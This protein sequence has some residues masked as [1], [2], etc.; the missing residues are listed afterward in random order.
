MRTFVINMKQD[1]A[2][3]KKMVSNFS[4]T[5]LNIERF[6]A[7]V[8]KDLRNREENNISNLCKLFCTNGM[9]GAMSSHMEV[10]KKIVHE[11]IPVAIIMEDDVSPVKDFND[12]LLKILNHYL[13]DNFDI[14]MLGNSSGSV[15]CD[16]NK[17]MN[18]LS[19]FFNHRKR[20]NHVQVN[21]WIHIP[22]NLSGCQ[23]YIISQKGAKKVLNQIKKISFHADDVIYS[24]DIHLYAVVPLLLR[25]DGAYEN[26]SLGEKHFIPLSFLNRWNCFGAPFAWALYEPLFQVGNCPISAFHLVVLS[27]LGVVLFFITRKWIFLGIVLTGWILSVTIT[28]GIIYGS[29]G[30]EPNLLCT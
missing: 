5:I 15:D 4:N 10:M 13:P 6:D 11:N 26:S 24:R 29:Y 30:R 9:I 17:M 28:R 21:P 25:H 16:E 1:T 8:G 3:W 20:R 23:G 19:I 27:V 14:V 7:V 12:T 18:H 22:C 2:R